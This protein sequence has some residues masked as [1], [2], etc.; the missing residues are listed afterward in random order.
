MQGSGLEIREFC[1]ADLPAML[2]VWNRIV[3]EGIA[4]PQLEPLDLKSG[5]DF[6]ASQS[7]TGVAVQGCSGQGAAAALPGLPELLGLYILHPNNLGRCG[8]LCNASYAV[9]EK[10]R[11]R[12]IGRQLVCHC[13]GQ[14]ARLG[15][16]ILQFNA[17]VATNSAALALYQKLG[18]T[19]LG[20][21]PGGF[22]LPDGSYGDI[23]PHYIELQPPATGQARA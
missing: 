21:I 20:R 7:F 9:H 22:L 18:F 4:F 8:H 5:R 11:G 2:P 14:A 16:R 15:F 3:E 23:I 12:G 17:V 10:A 19:R 1:E 6:F 13:M